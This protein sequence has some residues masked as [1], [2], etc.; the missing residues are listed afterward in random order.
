MP[1]LFDQ[2][3]VADVLTQR[4]AELKLELKKLLHNCPNVFG[5]FTL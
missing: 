4:V 3:T 5:E 1:D 2:A